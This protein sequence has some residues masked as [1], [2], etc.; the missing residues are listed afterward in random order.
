MLGDLGGWAPWLAAQPILP[1][2]KPN[3]A[4]PDTWLSLLES[5]VW[6]CYTHVHACPKHVAQV[7][8]FYHIHCCLHIHCLCHLTACLILLFLRLKINPITSSNGCVFVVVLGMGTNNIPQGKSKDHIEKTSILCKFQLFTETVSYAFPSK[9]ALTHEKCK[10]Y[11]ILFV[12]FIPNLKI[13][14]L[15]R[16]YCPY[17]QD[18]WLRGF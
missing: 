18:L 17:P 8:G 16:G 12:I 2:L 4:S 5:Q 1:K 14:A 15:W 13:S 11:W 9:N 6:R 7:G 10:E 3:G